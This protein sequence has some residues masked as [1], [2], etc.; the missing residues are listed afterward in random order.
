MSRPIQ[1]Y[2]FQVDLIWCDGT[3]KSASMANGRL[4]I[5][6]QGGKAV[7]LIFKI[8]VTEDEFALSVTEGIR[9]R[10]IYFLV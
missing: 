8:F 6:S 9:Q 4:K 10:R 2:H 1:P 3:F 7:C 5:R